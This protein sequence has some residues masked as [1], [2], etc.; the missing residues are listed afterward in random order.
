MCC[1]CVA[2][3]VYGKNWAE[4]R[5]QDIF[6]TFLALT[7]ST[8]SDRVESATPLVAEGQ[9]RGKLQIRQ[10]QSSPMCSHC[11]MDQPLRMQR[12][13]PSFGL[14]TFEVGSHL[15]YLHWDWSDAYTGLMASSLPCW[16]L[17]FTM[18]VSDSF[19]LDSHLHWDWWSALQSVTLLSVTQV[20][21]NLHWDW[22]HSHWLY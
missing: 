8:A 20:T 21:N 15:L 13:S 12:N 6:C 10:L 19:Y 17:Y 22:S 4:S 2:L 14:L 7:S 3:F 9:Q 1:V 5:E 16:A 18:I 11:F